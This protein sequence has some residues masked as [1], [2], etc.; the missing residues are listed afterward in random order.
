MKSLGR[1]LGSSARHSSSKVAK[2][3]STGVEATRFNVMAHAYMSDLMLC[4]LPWQRRTSGA[5]YSG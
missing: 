3:S 2:G 1:E 4:W 5:A